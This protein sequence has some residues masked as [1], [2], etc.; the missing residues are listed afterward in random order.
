MQAES[1]LLTREKVY[2]YATEILKTIHERM[3][4]L[5]DPNALRIDFGMEQLMLS[6]TVQASFDMYGQ[7]TGNSSKSNELFMA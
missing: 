6:T 7:A 4:Q 3:E 5:D 1:F 2:T